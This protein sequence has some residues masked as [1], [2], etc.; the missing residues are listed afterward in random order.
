[1]S[2]RGYL[3]L[4]AALLT[5]VLIALIGGHEPWSGPTLFGISSGHGVHL[6]DLPLVALWAA[7]LSWCV[8]RWRRL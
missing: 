5:A 6:G 7:G 1:M 4:G 3:A 8:R 2:E